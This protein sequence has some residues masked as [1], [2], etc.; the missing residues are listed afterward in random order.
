MPRIIAISG[1]K[2]SGKDLLA[3]YISKKYDYEHVKISEKL[4]DIC[5]ILFD[6]TDDQLEKDIKEE[7]D[8]RWNISPRKCMQF[9]GT[10]IMQFKVQEL[11]PEI[12][13]KFWIKSL[14]NSLDPNK[15]YVI[16]DLRFKH[17]YEELKKLDS[18]IVR[19]DTNNNN[20]LNTDDHVSE[21]EF[22]SIN[23]DIILLNDLVSDNMLKDFDI[24]L[25]QS[26]SV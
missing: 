12:N 9:I 18:L 26:Q 10:E 21:Q 22:K 23:A 24:K 3:N 4:K 6:F 20:L 5:K 13:R 8:P 17:E 11:L 14:L 15:K 1:F 7:I 25:V 2:R 16:S 19:I